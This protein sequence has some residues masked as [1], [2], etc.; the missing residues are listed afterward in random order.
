MRVQLQNYSFYPATGGIENYLYYFSKT[1]IEQENEAS[2]LCS[3]HL[4][5]LNEKEYYEN[6]LVNRH[7]TYKPQTP[8]G[9]MYP[10]YSC[11]KLQNFLK[12]E[13]NE[14]DLIIARHPHYAYSSSKT[15]KTPVVYVAASVW[16]LF[17][18]QTQME[19]EILKKLVFK[20]RYFQEYLIEKKALNN[21][22]KIIAL[23]KMRMKEIKD[24]YN[25]S[26]SNF[27]AISPGIDLEKFKPKNKDLN[28]LNELR[29]PQD[30]KVMLTVCRLSKEKNVETLIKAFSNIN[31]EKC[32]L[33]IVGDGPE[34]GSLQKLANKLKLNNR[35]IFTGFRKDVERFYSI[36]D[37]FI[38]LST[39]EGFGHVYLEALSSG[40]PCIA[41]KSD[42]PH[43][44]VASEEIISDGKTGYLINPYNVEDLYLKINKL[45]N[46]DDL[47]T[48]MSFKARET[49]EKK[50]SWDKHVN[51]VLKFSLK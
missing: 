13:Q 2:I 14:F 21:C 26:Q 49:C 36:A 38:L 40:V 6:I 15:F 33:V 19:R 43:I 47:R 48:K 7:P 27:K 25:I 5:N 22:D 44:I 23:S 28:L 32:F 41:L 45:L 11:K 50:Y 9:V 46:D 17:L 35:I 34:K 39:Y 18:K 42:Y 24:Y 37:L 51:N 10:I 16:P 20:F 4:P 31:D 8:F 3:K 1:L 29:I 12:A 30:S